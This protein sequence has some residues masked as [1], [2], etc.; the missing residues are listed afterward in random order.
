M[1]LGCYHFEIVGTWFLES[2]GDVDYYGVQIRTYIVCTLYVRKFECYLFPICKLKYRS[3]VIT[4]VLPE[5]MY[6]Y[7]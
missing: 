6:V 1:I 5:C 4:I 3:V 2:L 7:T